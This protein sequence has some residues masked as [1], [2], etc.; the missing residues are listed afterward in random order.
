MCTELEDGEAGRFRGGGAVFYLLFPFGGPGINFFR[1]I[2]WTQYTAAPE[3]MNILA[4][5]KVLSHPLFLQLHGSFIRRLLRTRCARVQEAYISMFL[6][7]KL[8]TSPDVKDQI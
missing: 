1:A 3:P 7:S 4:V 5:Y 6:V 8:K 2:F